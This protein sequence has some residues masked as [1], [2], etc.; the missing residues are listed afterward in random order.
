MAVESPVQQTDLTSDQLGPRYKWIVLFI[1]TMGM[2]MAMI[3]S[4]ITLIALPDTFRGIGLDPLQPGNSFYLLWMILGFMVV[5]SVL[6]TS[7]GR[8]GDIYGRVRIY[9][10]GFAV[11]TVFSLMLS[12]TWMHGEAAGMYLVIMRILQG[13]GAAM[14]IANSGA[15]LT[16]TFPP[17]QRGLAIGINSAAAFSGSFMGLILGGVLA[18]IE[19]R[20]IYLVSVP[21]GLVATV[22]G[23]FKLKE[24]GTR[25]P[26]QIDWW[27]NV[28]FAAGLIL[29]MIGITY[30]IEPYGDST[31]GWANPWVLLCLFGGVFLLGIF[32]FVESRVPD[33]M[34]RIALF[35]IRAFGAGV[36]ASALAS[37]ARGGLQFILIIWLQG[38]WLPLHGYSFSSTPLWAGISMLPLTVGMLIAGPTSG[39]LS[40]RFGARG[41]A[42]GGMLG[43]ALCFALI[44]QLPIDFNYAVFAV[45]MFFTGLFMGMF[46]S[47]NRSAVMSSLPE[48][49]RGAGAG[50]QSAFQNSASVLSI[51]VFFTLMIAGLS[52]VLPEAMY[53]G[54]TAHGVSAADA[55]RVAD[56][57]PVSTLFSAFLGYN[58]IQ[59]LL[60][61]DVLA[62]LP[63]SAQQQLV[64]REF[65]PS[66]ISKPFQHGLRT[67]LNFGIVASLIAAAASWSRGK[68]VPH[69][70]D[71]ESSMALPVEI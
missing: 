30:G 32:A 38:I 50:M 33:P 60:G 34:F 22:L 68:H 58:P 14:L 63:A 11:F 15:I 57:P 65:F 46:G 13:V 19:W 52:G 29:M 17:G 67:A 8:F 35:R 47:P 59:H 21:I 26:A 51:G 64:G 24:L 71:A 62:H 9:N 20:L 42:T 39:Y 53:A 43:T 69:D 10:L 3:D 12:I 23:Y 66:L 6:V 44:G 40:D 56:L 36:C 28:T 4:S 55:Q 25:R 7:L 45:L 37:L 31:M 27:G 2:L 54:L 41:F 16:D 61:T 18:P 49:H 1:A 70:A 48:E 5:T